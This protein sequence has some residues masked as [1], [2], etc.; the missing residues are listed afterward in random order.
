MGNCYTLLRLV[1]NGIWCLKNVGDWLILMVIWN[2][3]WVRTL[4]S[5]QWI[6]ALCIINMRGS[7]TWCVCMPRIN[8]QHWDLS[9]KVKAAPIRNVTRR[10]KSLH[11]NS[12]INKC[13]LLHIKHTTSH[14][15]QNNINIYILCK[16]HVGRLSNHK[17]CGT[18]QNTFANNHTHTHTFRNKVPIIYSRKGIAGGSGKQLSYPTWPFG[19]NGVPF[20]FLPLLQ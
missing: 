17:D 3:I 2:Y 11:S 19:Q 12:T 6:S 10:Q 13:V 9:L 14:F 16:C 7:G 18:R 8:S 4:F 20:I 1:F 15:A 5:Y